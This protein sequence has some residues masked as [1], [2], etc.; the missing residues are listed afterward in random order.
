M[1]V[2]DVSRPIAKRNE[3]G[4]TLFELGAREISRAVD[5]LTGIMANMF[6]IVL[7]I[8]KGRWN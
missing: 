8:Q 3:A 5:M 1:I 7:P 6:G 2:V 4:D